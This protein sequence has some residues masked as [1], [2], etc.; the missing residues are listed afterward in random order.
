MPNQLTFKGAIYY[1]T[2]TTAISLRVKI[3]S[4]RGKAHLVFHWYLYDKS[5]YK[6]IISLYGKIWN[7]CNLFQNW[8]RVYTCS[9]RIGLQTFLRKKHWARNHISLQMA[10]Y[11]IIWAFGLSEI[12]WVNDNILNR[13]GNSFVHSIISKCKTRGKWFLVTSE[14]CNG[15]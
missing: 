2:I 1:V 11:L 14:G 9:L 10:H 7:S 12:R 3:W 5:Q 4:F 15:G 6:I 8:E 13:G